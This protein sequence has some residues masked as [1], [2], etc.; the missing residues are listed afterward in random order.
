MNETE[1]NR[2]SEVL[3]KLSKPKTFYVMFIL[4][5]LYFLDYVCRSIISPLY[6]YLKADLHLND[7]Q[8]GMLSTV[9]TGNDMYSGGFR[10]P[11]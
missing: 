7:A 9:C 8:L 10:Y 2:D 5:I 3:L 11:I 4:Y 6:P 1:T